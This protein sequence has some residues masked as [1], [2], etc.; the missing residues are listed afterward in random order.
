MIA[1]LN[2]LV[3]V[4]TP[5]W[6]IL[7]V[8]GVGYQVNI[9]LN[10]FYQLPEPKNALSLY[11]HTHVREDALQ[12][13]GFLST[14]E[15][16]IFNL[17]LGVSGIGPK[18][19]ITVLSGLSAGDLIRAIRSE[20]AGCLSNISGIGKKTA[21]RLILELKEKVIALTSEEEILSP[22]FSGKGVQEEDGKFEEVLSAMVNLGYNRQAIKGKTEALFRKNPT[23]EL[24]SLIK[25]SL[26]MLGSG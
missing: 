20:D 19:A 6:I 7:D 2:G 12:L 4:K 11:I 21:S 5:P 8:G 14:R 22:E 17:L 1:W 18:L 13:F 23:L 15:R 24:E 9:S 26:R 10:T 25:E 16:E 3:M